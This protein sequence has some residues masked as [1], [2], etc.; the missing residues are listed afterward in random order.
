MANQLI[1]FGN[2][3]F[4]QSIEKSASTRQRFFVDR[5]FILGSLEL[6]L[7]IT[8]KEKE[9]DLVKGLLYLEKL[10]DRLPDHKVGQLYHAFML[11]L[12]GYPKLAEEK[13][14]KQSSNDKRLRA[15]LFF[16]A[17]IKAQQG[18]TVACYQY[19]A[20]SDAKQRLSLVKEFKA[21]FPEDIQRS[22]S[23]QNAIG[24]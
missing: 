18:E 20:K 16:L 24:H 19:L 12:L 9:G 2:R 10:L 13:I 3:R 6:Y 22:T 14:V 11:S 4:L 8:S 15:P 1:S 17:V 7:W 5:L 21:L 23:F